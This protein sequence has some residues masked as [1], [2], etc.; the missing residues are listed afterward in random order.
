MAVFA[1]LAELN[2]VA[3]LN[4]QNENNKIIKETLLGFFVC[5]YFFRVF[6]FFILILF[7]KNHK[8]EKETV[9]LSVNVYKGDK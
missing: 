8:K 9:K 1:Y 3:L 7:M 2:A 6:F 4:F 5:V